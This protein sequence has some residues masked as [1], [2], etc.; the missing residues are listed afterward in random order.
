MKKFILGLLIAIPLLLGAA[1]AKEPTTDIS[2]TPYR[3][4]TATGEIR[5]GLLIHVSVPGK[6]T[7]TFL[8]IDNELFLNG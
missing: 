6:R 1:A 7:F 4:M 8:V 2:S 3:E 5:E